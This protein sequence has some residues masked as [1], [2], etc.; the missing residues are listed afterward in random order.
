MTLRVTRILFGMLKRTESKNKNA[1][2]SKCPLKM[3]TAWPMTNLVKILSPHEIKSRE[4]LVKLNSQ[5]CSISAICRLTRRF[6]TIGLADCRNPHSC[7][8]TSAPRHT[9][10]RYILNYAGR[11][12]HTYSHIL[13]TLLCA[14]TSTYRSSPLHLI[15][16]LD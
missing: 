6:C 7:A 16:S 15:R 10:I 11:G 12:A 8:F 9:R 14:T 2:M 3:S 1:C 4:I 5:V 13:Y